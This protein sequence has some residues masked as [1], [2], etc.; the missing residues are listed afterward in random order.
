[1]RHGQELKLRQ[2][3]AASVLQKRSY[4]SWTPVRLQIHTNERDIMQSTHSMKPFDHSKGISII[5]KHWD[6]DAEIVL[7]PAPRRQRYR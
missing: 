3:L 4:K 7:R 5:L 6:A 1:M 2:A